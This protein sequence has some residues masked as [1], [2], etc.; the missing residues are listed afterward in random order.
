MKKILALLLAL[1][2]TLFAFAGCGNDEFVITVGAS[3]TPHK[4]I[5][6]QCR[7]YIEEK[8]YTLEIKEFTDYH[9]PNSTLSGGDLD[10]NYFQ[11][12]QYLADQIAVHGYEFTSVYSAHYEPLGIYAG[13]KGTTLADLKAGDKIAIPEDL[14]NGARALQLLA[15]NGVIEITNDQG[16]NT[17]IKDIDS[18]GLEII[19]LEAKLI[20][21]MLPDLSFGVINGNYALDFDIMD[22]SVAFEDS[23]IDKFINIIVVNTADIDSE[24]TKILVEAL[25]QQ[26]VKDYITETFQG[27]VIPYTA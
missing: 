11:H 20:G 6:E 19:A 17:T 23:T 22:S 12:E 2:L 4:Q 24:K 27:A 1:S 16:L 15:D 3:P 8:G 26:S 18:K 13:G 14:T 21:P 9:L 5:L 10:A 25:S 7:P